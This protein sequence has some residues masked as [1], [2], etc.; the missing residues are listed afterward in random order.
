MNK[1]NQTLVT[2]GI[3]VGALIILFIVGVVESIDSKLI[4]AAKEV[5]AGNAI[6]EAALYNAESDVHPVVF[7]DVG[8]IGENTALWHGFSKSNYP[9]RL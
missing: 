8:S 5:C 4:Q 6:A 2:C 7:V 1:Q 3:I 9:A